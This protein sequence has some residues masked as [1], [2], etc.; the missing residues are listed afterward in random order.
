MNIREWKMLLDFVVGFL[1]MLL[2]EIGCCWISFNRL[3]WQWFSWQRFVVN[4]RAKMLLDML[5]DFWSDL[6]L[7]F[8]FMPSPS[9]LNTNR[10]A[11]SPYWL[12]VTFF[13]HIFLKTFK[14]N[15]LN[16]LKINKRWKQFEKIRRAFIFLLWSN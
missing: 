5:L 1:E 9:L 7:L 6:E 8:L 14:L 13:L 3:L 4:G 11:P 10:L 16:V 15:E 12:E 2:D